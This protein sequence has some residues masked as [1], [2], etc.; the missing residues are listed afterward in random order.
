MVVGSTSWIIS[1]AK[2]H[3]FPLVGVT[4]VEVMNPSPLREWLQAGYGAEMD[5]L[6]RH[7]PIRADLRTVLP[8]AQSVICVALPYPGPQASE[9]STVSIA[10][11]ARGADYHDVI[12]ERL[13]NLW[14]EIR[15]TN[16]GAEGS[17]FID[18]GPLPERELARRA[19][20]GWVGK[21]SCLI[22]PNYGSRFC[23]GEILTTL[24]LQPT[25]AL[26]EQCGDCHKCL[27]ACPTGALVAPGIVD[28]R[29]CLS[30][31]TIEHKGAIPREL[32]PLLGTRL[33]GCDAC[34]DACPYNQQLGTIDS[35]LQPYPDLLAPDLCALLRLS[36]QEFNTRFRNTPLA[37]AKRR[38]VLRNVCVVLGNMHD[39][40]AIHLLRATLSDA[41]PVL[42]GHYAWALGMI[43]GEQVVL[44]DALSIEE[45]NW[46][47]E[48]IAY[49][50]LPR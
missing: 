10:K 40:S 38:G 21:H 20:L 15:A 26:P 36:P 32:R 29:R 2:A 46:V 31:L 13:H 5:Y 16:T 34:Q 22:H 24:K 11:Y 37:R 23:L 42:R 41:E 1:R 44:R 30:Y 49:A 7:L 6:P 18:S 50:L 17:I 39:A 43:G 25:S 4:A 45:D 8:G 14:Q 3:G 33:F 27:C 47:R 9:S 19:G 35:V 12:R 28:S 48:E